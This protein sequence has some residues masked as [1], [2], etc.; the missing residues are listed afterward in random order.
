[1]HCIYDKFEYKG[2]EYVRYYYPQNG[3]H[4]YESI[5]DYFKTG[6]RSFNMAES[7]AGL[8]RMINKRRADL[9][10]RVEYGICDWSV[11]I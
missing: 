1:M 2:I 5:G 10:R 8:T 9:E 4:W 6:L 7:K 11:G 3:Q